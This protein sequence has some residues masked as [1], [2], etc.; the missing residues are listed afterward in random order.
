MTVAH[1]AR[2]FCAMLGFCISE[3]WFWIIRKSFRSTS[4]IVCYSRQHSVLSS[5]VFYHQI[6]KYCGPWG[7]PTQSVCINQMAEAPLT[8]IKPFQLS[9][10]CSEEG[11]F[12]FTQCIFDWKL[13]I[14]RLCCW[15]SSSGQHCKWWHFEMARFISAKHACKNTRN[16]TKPKMLAFNLTSASD[17]RGLF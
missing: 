10:L 3:K 5:L 11:V 8:S 15:S 16:K 4:V 9:A 1:S 7:Q 12:S 6:K 14:R 17:R 13:H 2:S